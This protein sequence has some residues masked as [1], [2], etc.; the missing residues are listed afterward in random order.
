MSAEQL[1]REARRHGL[2]VNDL[3]AA[4]NSLGDEIHERTVS[5]HV[6][7]VR[8]RLRD[9]T[10][11]TYET[12]LS[13][14]VAVHGDR[15]VADITYIDLE[16]FT[17]DV[18]KNR[19][20]R[21][22]S[23]NDVVPENCVG[24]LR[25]MFALAVKHGIRSDNPA[26]LIDKARRVAQ[27]PRTALRRNEI[28]ELV[29]VTRRDSNDP[30]L[31]LLLIRFMLETG[32]RRQGILDLTEEDI[33]ITANRVRL[34]EKGGTVRWQPVTAELVVQLLEHMK[35]RPTDDGVDRVFRQ[36]LRSGQEFHQPI[37]QKRFETLTGYWKNALGWVTQLGVSAHW[38]R[39][40]AITSMDRIGGYAVARSFAG[41]KPQTVTDRYVT[42]LPHELLKAF[43]I[44]VGLD[45]ADDNEYVLPLNVFR[46][47]SGGAATRNR[48]ST[49]C[50]EPKTTRNRLHGRNHDSGQQPK[51][52][53]QATSA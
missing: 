21:R 19:T 45:E 40:T 30:D 46:N 42:A 12:Y 2:S 44:Y 17:M 5:D 52:S 26:E 6:E 13:R 3:V 49:G 34:T 27:E 11:A 4:F 36:Q 14:F 25:N 53:V 7:M 9:G 8:N 23:R 37:T 32:C 50:T 47:N 22:N 16:E 48:R 28:I 15:R 24:A 43:N 20:K 1:A 29:N 39:H 31:D 41:H 35:F 10:R 51:C 18:V 33:D 38:L